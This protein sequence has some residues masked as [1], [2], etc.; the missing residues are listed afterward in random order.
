GGHR[1]PD[2]RAAAGRS[3]PRPAGRRLMA[4]RPPGGRR[5]V[6]SGRGVPV[7][8]RHGGGRAAART[9][10]PLERRAGDVLAGNGVAGVV[11]GDCR[12]AR[13]RARWL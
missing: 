12:P 8:A 9:P 13:A 4:E 11:R 5:R 3:R 1:H 10:L 2:R 6:G 7:A